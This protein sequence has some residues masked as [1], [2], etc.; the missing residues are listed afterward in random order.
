MFHI[1]LLVIDRQE[2]LENNH[3]LTSDEELTLFD[4]NWKNICCLWADAVKLLSEN[5]SVSNFLNHFLFDLEFKFLKKFWQKLFS[6]KC[7]LL[8][9]WLKTVCIQI[10]S[11]SVSAIIHVYCFKTHHYRNSD[12]F[13]EM[14][15]CFWSDYQ[16]LCIL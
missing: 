5:W 10:I 6:W 1:L 11:V 3:F 15:S 8:T 13:W 16:L 14:L 12:T 2:V 9:Q 7:R 4:S